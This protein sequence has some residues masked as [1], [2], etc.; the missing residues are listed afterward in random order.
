MSGAVVSVPVEAGD[1]VEAGDLLVV[2]EA[3]K[4]EHAISAQGRATVREVLCAPG[5]Q[6]DEGEALI[7]LDLGE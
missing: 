5:D 6:V 3:M 2:I 1:Q 7:V 4:M